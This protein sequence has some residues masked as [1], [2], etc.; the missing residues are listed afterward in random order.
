MA[1]GIHGQYLFV[2]REREIVIAKVSSQ[3]LPLDSQRIALTLDAVAQI[4]DW[5]EKMS[6]GN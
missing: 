4:R 3:P 6:S 1:L 2:D 5:L